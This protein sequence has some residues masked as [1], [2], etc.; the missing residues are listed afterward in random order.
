MVIVVS[1]LILTTVVLLGFSVE[2][3]S[4]RRGRRG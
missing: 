3:L 4:E 2:T 1:Q